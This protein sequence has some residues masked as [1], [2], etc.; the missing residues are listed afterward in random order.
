MKNE[1]SPPIESRPVSALRVVFAL[2]VAF[3]PS[4]LVFGM[5]A[6]FKGRNV[7]T[8]VLITESLFCLA[9]CSAPSLLLLRRYPVLAV[10]VSVLFIPLNGLIAFFF[11]CTAVLSAR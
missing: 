9:C 11:G 5:F 1:S 4:A 3:L 7:P 10:V 2:A 6:L 8:L